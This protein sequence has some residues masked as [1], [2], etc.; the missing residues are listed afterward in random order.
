MRENTLKK[1]LAALVDDFGYQR[2]RNSLASISSTKLK[3]DV[4]RKS[5]ADG[6]RGPRVRPNAIT[7]VESL[8]I[9]DEEKKNVLQIL[10]RHFED[11]SFLPNLRSV[12][13]FLAKE[14]RDISRFKSRQQAVSV[15]F[16]CL[17]EWETHN[18]YDMQMKGLYG[19]PK[20]LAAIA[21][22]IE[23]VA[24]QNRG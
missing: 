15:V 19:G 2:V 16:E 7:I 20:S 13:A 24:Q 5:S 11:K 3:G 14:A 17:A 23:S 22:S 6:Y 8:E 1:I 18:L 21:D 12:R 10:A 4:T 9:D